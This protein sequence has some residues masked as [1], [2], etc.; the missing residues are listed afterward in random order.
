MIVEQ[1]LEKLV[2]MKL[3]TMAKSLQERLSRS[4]HSDLSQSDFIGLI[5]DDEWIHRENRRMG[6]LIKSAA[7]KDK[8]ACLESIDYSVSRGIKKSVMLELGQNHWINKHQNILITGPSGSGKSYLA[9][10]LSSHAC[11]SG[12]SC[13]Y[14]RVSRLAQ[15]LSQSRADGSYAK[16]LKKLSKCRVLILD[17]FGISKIT[18]EQRNDILE[19]LEDRYR[20]GS[21]IITSQLSVQEWHPYLGGERVADAICD[22]IVHNSHRIEV[23]SI[24]SLRKKEEEK[25]EKHV[26]IKKQNQ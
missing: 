25:N 9:Q 10:A 22:R 14:Y 5:V 18:V 24:E 13:G 11:R 12:Y 19:I 17:D 6:T 2:K 26:E 4:D 15:T 23:S 20:Q 7:F 8:E 21:T 3:A 1:T 16:L